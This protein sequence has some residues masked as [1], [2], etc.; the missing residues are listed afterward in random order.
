MA[1][2]FVHR[3]R[4]ACGAVRFEVAGRRMH[5]AHCLCQTCQRAAGA[6]IV[7]WGTISRERLTIEGEVRWWRSS[8]RAERG[9]CGACGTSLFY[10]P[11]DQRV[12]WMDLTVVSLETAAEL[13]P[14]YA[15]WTSSRLP[16]A[17]L[18]P[19]LPTHEESGPDWVPPAV[20]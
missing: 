13:V 14:A 3:G 10:R 4:C 9:F 8:D 1:T 20:E 16:W 6:P 15:I 11:L 12:P 19:A 7:T 5:V 17:H 2:P 18:D